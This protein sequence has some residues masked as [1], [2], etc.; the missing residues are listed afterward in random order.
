MTYY[1]IK[2]TEIMMKIKTRNPERNLKQDLMKINW[3]KKWKL[4]WKKTKTN[5]E[6]KN[7]GTRKQNES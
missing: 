5:K 6:N 2:T 1:I 7:F 4:N 3:S